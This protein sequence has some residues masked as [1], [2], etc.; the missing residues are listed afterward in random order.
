V[1]PRPSTSPP[2][3]SLR[4]L[5]VIKGLVYPPKVRAYLDYFEAAGDVPLY[6]CMAV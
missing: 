4:S 3:R 1:T 6:D 2:T 5:T